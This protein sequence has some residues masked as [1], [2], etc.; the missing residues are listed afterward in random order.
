MMPSTLLAVRPASPRLL[1]QVREQIRLKHFSLL[2]NAARN[3]SRVVP[4][5]A[6]GASL[7]RP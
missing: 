4:V 6:D 7:T 2:A 1:D 3:P 5:I